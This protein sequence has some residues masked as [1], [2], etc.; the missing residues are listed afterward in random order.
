M[1]HRHHTSVA[2]LAVSVNCVYS[3]TVEKKQAKPEKVHLRKMKT[4]KTIKL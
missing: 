3:R 2:L 4:P 1:S